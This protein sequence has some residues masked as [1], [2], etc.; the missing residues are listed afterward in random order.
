MTELE[1]AQMRAAEFTNSLACLYH[2]QQLLAV[3]EEAKGS[4]RDRTLPDPVRKQAIQDLRHV[5]LQFNVVAAA[6]AVL[7][8]SA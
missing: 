8:I 5:N 7:G 6:R 1:E 4:I 3:G 2:I